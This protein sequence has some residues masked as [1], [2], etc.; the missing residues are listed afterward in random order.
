MSRVRLRMSPRKWLTGLLLAGVLAWP[1]AAKVREHRAVE[2]AAESARVA[3]ESGRVQAAEAPVARYLN[4]RP[5]SALAHALAAQLALEKGALDKVTDELNQARALGYPKAKLERL[6]AITL[7]RIGRYG[8]AEP[9]LVRLFQGGATTDPMV[10]A[11]L[12]RVYL[13]TYRLKQAEEVIRQWIQDAP[14]DG[15]PYLWL[16]EIDR[17]MEVDNLD[18]QKRHYRQAL[19]HDP[20]LDAARLG[21]AQ[22]LRKMHQNAEAKS[23]YARYLERHPQDPVALNGAGRNALERGDVAGAA[24]SLDR[25][26][27]IAPTDIDVLKG[28]ASLEMARREPRDALTCLDRALWIDPFDTESLYARSRARA[29]LGDQAGAAKDLELFKKYERDHA[30]LLALRGSL[31]AHPANNDLRSQVAR[32]MFAHGRIEE[33]LGWANAVLGSDPNHQAANRLLA[34][35]YAK[36]PKTAGLANFYLLRASA[37]ES[38]S[39]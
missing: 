1:I 38:G 13:M 19:D 31:M 2:R 32:W 5:G 25:A 36:E 34:D 37:R 18:T 9:I 12:A 39:Q 17:R 21:L 28:R 23:E 3:L 10:D 11:A 26:F 33:G 6:H 20:D 29:A 24:D 4:A 14:A 22:T 8:E 7:A 35:H 15:R 16:T 27:A 30:D